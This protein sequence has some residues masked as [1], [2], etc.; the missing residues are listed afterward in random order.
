M[1]NAL[2]CTKMHSC[3]DNR[4]DFDKAKGSQQY[5]LACQLQERNFKAVHEHIIVI[6]KL[7]ITLIIPAKIKILNARFSRVLISK[8]LNR[9]TGVPSFPYKVHIASKHT[10]KQHHSNKAQHHT[11]H[12]ATQQHSTISTTAQSITEPSLNFTNLLH[13]FARMLSCTPMFMSSVI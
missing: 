9:S 7:T 5:I 8:S 11:M 2:H 12:T 6:S 4:R 10:A 13:D 1:I 3:N